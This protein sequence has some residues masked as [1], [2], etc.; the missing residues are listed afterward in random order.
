MSMGAPASTRRGILLSTLALP[1]LA[2][3]FPDRP[4]RF[5]VPYSAGGG[6]DVTAREVAQRMAPLLGQPV[7]VE[8][9]TGANTA[10]GAEHVA[11]ARPDGYTLYFAGAASLVVPPLVWPRLPYAVADFAP[12]GLVLKQPYGLG[13]GPWAATSLEDLLAKM[14][15]A[16]GSFSFGHTGTGSTGHLLGERLMA[17]TGTR[18]LSVPYRGFAQTVVDIVGERLQMTFEAV[19][20]IL[21]F[22]R[23]GQVPLR[24]VTSPARLPQLPEVPTFT[25]SGLPGM[26]VQS[27]LALFAPAATPAPVVQRLNAVLRRVVE[28]TEFRDYAM[29]QVQFAEAS[30]PEGMAEY[31]ARDIAEWRAVIAPLNLRVD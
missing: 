16:P 24:A 14:R 29:G 9:R 13:V 18:M 12:V 2:Q 26:E 31:L 1:A 27:W 23:S 10:I 30:T 6:T 28:S 25:E 17:A 19:N 21:S 15:A 22:H 3:T 7:V 5:I 4:I 8:N 11:R 20:N